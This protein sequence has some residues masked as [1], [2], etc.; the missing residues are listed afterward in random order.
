MTDSAVSL[1]Q[2]SR[3]ESFWADLKKG[4]DLF[5]ASKAP[6]VVSV[7]NGRYVFEPGSLDTVSQPVEERCQPKV[8]ETP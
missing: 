8:A 1:R 5:E 4:Y 3:W 2:G 6:P 7:C